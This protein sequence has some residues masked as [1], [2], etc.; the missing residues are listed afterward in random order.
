M[1]GCF[2]STSHC[3]F[4]GLLSGGAMIERMER[5]AHH[6]PRRPEWRLTAW[7]AAAIVVTAGLAFSAAACGG[8]SRSPV[9][10]LGTTA[11]SGSSS[12]PPTAQPNGTTA[13]ARCMRSEGVR[14]FPD[15]DSN[16]SLPKVSLQQLGV[17]SS[18]FLAANKACI[19]LLPNTSD[20][21]VTQCFETGNCPGVLLQRLMSGMLQFA[22]CMRSHGVPNWPDPTTSPGRGPGFNLLHVQG[23]APNSPQI[24]DKMNQCQRPGVRI[25]LERP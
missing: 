16:G 24:E 12:S 8:S 20:S 11:K 9:A 1:R 21:S 17:S 4:L 18:Q 13:F 10:Q 6:R 19:H 25:A 15:P 14:T 2:S 5:F 23:F 3:R 7:T 22:R